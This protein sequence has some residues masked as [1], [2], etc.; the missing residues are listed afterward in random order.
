MYWI[1]A[2]NSASAVKIFLGSKETH[3]QI[4]EKSENGQI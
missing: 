2:K 4:Y 1:I 3:A